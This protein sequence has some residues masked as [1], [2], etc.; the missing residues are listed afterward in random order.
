MPFLPTLPS[1]NENHLSKNLNFDGEKLLSVVVG[2]VSSLADRALD[3]D[4]TIFSVSL[5]IFKV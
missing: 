2:P 1:L 5:S 3:F 4:D